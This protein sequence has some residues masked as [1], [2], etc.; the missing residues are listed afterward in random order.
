MRVEYR[1]ELDRS[2]SWR[3]CGMPVACAQGA[4]VFDVASIRPSLPDGPKNMVETHPGGLFVARQISTRNLVNIAF[5]PKAVITTG[6]AAWHDDE[7]YDIDARAEGAGEMMESEAA[8]P[9]LAL[10]QD[11]FGLVIHE[12]SPNATDPK[13]APPDSKKIRAKSARF[14]ARPGCQPLPLDRGNPSVPK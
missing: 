10:L 8:V 4:P 2:A 6:A 9:M 7:R 12:E 3:D 11:G 5:G 1:Y 14:R 13:R